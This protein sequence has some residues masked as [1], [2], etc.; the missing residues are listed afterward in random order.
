MPGDVLGSAHRVLNAHEE[1][2]KAADIDGVVANAADDIVVLLP[3]SPL[4]EGRAAFQEFYGNLLATGPAEF[5]HHY[6]G[7]EVLGNSA[8]FHGVARGTATGP[9]GS[10]TAMENNFIL[11]LKPDTVGQ[12]KIWRV[13]FGPT[14]I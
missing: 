7:E 13:A 4:I 1:A 3:G 2:M 10:P 9:D 11:V 6:S 12:M 8:V 5:Q 14:S